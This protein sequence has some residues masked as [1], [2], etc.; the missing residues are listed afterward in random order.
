MHKFEKPND[1]KGVEIMLLAGLS[2]MEA[3]DEIF[4]GY[5]QSDEFSFVFRK[6][7]ELYNRRTEKILTSIYLIFLFINIFFYT[8]IVINFILL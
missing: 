5:G 7:A 2:V 8:F 3:F 4:M 6:D 1:R